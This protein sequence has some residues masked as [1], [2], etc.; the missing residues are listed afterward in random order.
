MIL[1]ADKLSVK[2]KQQI[3]AEINASES[4]F[5]SESDVADFKV[6][7]FTP[8][9]EIAFCGHNTIAAFYV[10]SA[11]N[12]VKSSE[13]GSD[14]TEETKAGIVP[15][16]VSKTHGNIRVAM[17]QNKPQ[18]QSIAAGREVIARALRIDVSELDDR[19]EIKYSNTG[20]WHLIVAVKAEERLHQIS[21][22]A[23][24]LSLLLEE[25]GAVTAHVFCM[26]NAHRFHA[27]NFGPTYGIPEDPATGAAAGA[28]GAYLVDQGILTEEFNQF[29][30]L[31]GEAM[32]RPSTIFVN[33][34]QHNG[35]VKK[36]EVSGTAVI[37]FELLMEPS[38]IVV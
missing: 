13:K 4:A 15:V 32:G 14:F 6:E 33:I 5:I 36:V 8:T 20:N 37:S 26:K 28:F 17:T 21:Y 27:R 1:D 2:E 22:D 29:E 24:E 35:E 38:L 12:R 9:R 30:I 7:F 11:L 18:F 23:N 3:A 31:Q 16:R 34:Q 10:L 19:F 25:I